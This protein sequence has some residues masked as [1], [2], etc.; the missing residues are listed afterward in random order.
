MYLL[1]RI[2]WI[3]TVVVCATIYALPNLYAKAP[4]LKIS[5]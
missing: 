2:F 5:A 4:A 1:W 3:G